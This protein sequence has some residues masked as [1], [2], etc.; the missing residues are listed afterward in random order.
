MT[1]VQCSAVSPS[2]C[3]QQAA[4]WTGGWLDGGEGMGVGGCKLR[5]QLPVT[6]ATSAG[7]P[8]GCRA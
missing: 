1:G 6:A 3:F 4:G 7:T 5:M 8:K 2:Q